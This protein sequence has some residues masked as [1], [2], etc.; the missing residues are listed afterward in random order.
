LGQNI[1]I[2]YPFFKK[3]KNERMQNGRDSQEPVQLA[4]AEIWNI[5][6]IELEEATPNEYA[7]LPFEGRGH[8]QISKILT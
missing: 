7:W 5:E 3:G 6:E 2:C 4:L 8:S 1:F